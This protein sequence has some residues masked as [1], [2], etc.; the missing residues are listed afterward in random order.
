MSELVPRSFLFRDSHKGLFEFRREFDQ[1]LHC[2]LIHWPIS[3]APPA[4]S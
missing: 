1:I 4:A 3:E 2:S